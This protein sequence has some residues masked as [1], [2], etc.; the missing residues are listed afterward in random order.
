MY[1]GCT[2][3]DNPCMNRM[4]PLAFI[5]NFWFGQGFARSVKVTAPSQ[6]LGAR[7]IN[8][9][10]NEYKDMVKIFGHDLEEGYFKKIIYSHRRKCV[11]STGT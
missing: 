5:F 1:P 6:R 2:L 4:K 11:G 9:R 10:F 3:R 7:K 8:G